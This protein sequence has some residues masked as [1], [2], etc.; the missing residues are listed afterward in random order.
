MDGLKPA[1]LRPTDALGRMD[2]AQLETLLARH[3]RAQGYAVES[4]GTGAIGAKVGDAIDLVLR[5]ED[6]F[7]LVQCR[8]WT[9]TTVS[10]DAVQALLDVMA[11]LDATGGVLVTGGTFSSAA[12]EVASRK[13]RV[14]L[15]DGA[16]VH[17]ML[18]ALPDR[19]DEA[20]LRVDVEVFDEGP[21][22]GDSMEWLMLSAGD[23]ARSGALLGASAGRFVWLSLG[24]K[25]TCGFALILLFA[26]AIDTAVHPLLQ[27]L[28]LHRVTA[29]AELLSTPGGYD[30]RPAQSARQDPIVDATPDAWHQPSE[31]EILEQQRK[32]HAA[33][34]VEKDHTS[35]L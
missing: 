33:Q 3:C 11:D 23:R 20:P 16:T 22:A 32:A 2:R 8:H 9:A 21:Y 6:E 10:Q 7:V 25:V 17:T 31:D 28:R 26:W 13:G 35:A 24:L 14:E 4:A 19:N 5:R 27:P 34:M 30:M 12:I 1:S 18:G 15:V 29:D